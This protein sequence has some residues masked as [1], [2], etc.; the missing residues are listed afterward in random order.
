MILLSSRTFTGAWI[1]TKNDERRNWRYYVAPSRVRELK[2]QIVPMGLKQS[3]SHLHG[4]VNWNGYTE[5]NIEY[6]TRRTFTGAWIETHTNFISFALST[7][8]TFTGAWIETS[9]AKVVE[10]VILSHL[11]GCVNWN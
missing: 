7:G 6:K 10:E 3:L 5:R 2:R 4:C 9:S 1:E 11:H 8:R